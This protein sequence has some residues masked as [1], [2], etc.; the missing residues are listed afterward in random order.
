MT[1]TVYT[2]TQPGPVT[3]DLALA[4]GIIRVHVDNNTHAQITICTTD[5]DGPSA[6]A[7]NNTHIHE[8]NGRIIAHV[9]GTRGVGVIN[10]GGGIF[11]AGDSMSVIQ[12][13]YGNAVYVNG[14]LVQGGGAVVVG[15]A[16]IVLD[17]YLPVGSSLI[18]STTSADVETSGALDRARVETVSGDIRIGA[19]ASPGLRTTSGGIEIDALSGDADVQTVS[20]DIRINATVPCYVRASSVSGDVRT[21]GAR[22]DLDARSVSGRIRQ[23]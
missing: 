15:G 17:A 12:T 8:Q 13:G 4:A 11:V 5:A 14:V 9:P 3:V 19:V 23:S 16:P 7:V 1:D 2:A 10:S 18:A 20:G 21:S 6:D 22:I